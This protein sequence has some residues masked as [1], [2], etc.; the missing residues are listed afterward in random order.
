MAF[1]ADH[2]SEGKYMDEG[3]HVA[4]IVSVRMFTY[5]SGGPGVEF[6]LINAE[7]REIKIGFSL[8]ETALWKLASF[9]A[10]C[11]LTKEECRDYNS[12]SPE[13][14]NRLVGRKMNIVVVK[15]G[16]YHEVDEWSKLEIGQPATE[17]PKLTPPSNPT[18]VPE[19]EPTREPSL[20]EIF[21]EDVP[22]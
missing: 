2:W 18:L 6:K 19:S 16:K 13:S 22:F 12:N 3:N 8:K 21:G 9:V 11:G 20:N 7:K 15:N 1:L 10:A 17:E 14:H 4:K 5:T